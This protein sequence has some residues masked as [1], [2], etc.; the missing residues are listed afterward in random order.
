MR[1]VEYYIGHMVLVVSG[2]NRDIPLCC[3]SW[4]QAGRLGRTKACLKI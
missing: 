2:V 4:V 3:G 1:Y